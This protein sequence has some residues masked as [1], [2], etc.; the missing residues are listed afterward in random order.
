M[1]RCDNCQ[2]WVQSDRHLDHLGRAS[3]KEGQ[4]EPVGE[5]HKGPPHPSIAQGGPWR[6]FPA[7]RASDG[8]WQWVQAAPIISIQTLGVAI[9]H[10]EKLVRV[11]VDELVDEPIKPKKALTK[12]ETKPTSPAS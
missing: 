4:A 2:S 10:P 1:N 7:T 11:E 3:S 8:C 12:K 9:L 5:C 6:V